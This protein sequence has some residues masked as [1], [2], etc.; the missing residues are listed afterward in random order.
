MNQTDQKYNRSNSIA[1]DIE[2]H[3]VNK[4]FSLDSIVPFF[5]VRKLRVIY[6]ELQG[7]ENFNFLSFEAFKQDVLSSNAPQLELNKWEAI[8]SRR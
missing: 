7:N 5:S 6:N 8:A 1:S 3:R 2:V 4:S